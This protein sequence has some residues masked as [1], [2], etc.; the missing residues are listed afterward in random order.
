MFYPVWN[1]CTLGSEG[2]NLLFSSFHQRMQLWLSCLSLD[3]M[4]PTFCQSTSS[5]PRWHKQKNWNCWLLQKGSFPCLL[6]WEITPMHSTSL[7]QTWQLL[8]CQEGLFDLRCTI[9]LFIT[10]LY[11]FSIGAPTIVVA[12]WR[13]VTCEHRSLSQVCL[14]S[15]YPLI[16]VPITPFLLVL[17][18]CIFWP[19]NVLK[20]FFLISPAFHPLFSC[21][22]FSWPPTPSVSSTI[23]TSYIDAI[24]DL[25]KHVHR[26]GCVFYGGIR[27]FIWLS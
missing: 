17:A 13:H 14:L 23:Y 25:I 24:T 15:L 27:N 26:I 6:S 16:P 10:T 2:V 7:W 8:M 9:I 20:C 12:C 4:L 21:P 5:R 3:S 11:T 22:L 1:F 19:Q 18:L